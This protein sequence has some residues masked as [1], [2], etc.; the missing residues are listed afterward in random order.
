MRGTGR[1]RG[2]AWHVGMQ[3]LDQQNLIASFQTRLEMWGHIIAVLMP[4]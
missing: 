3:V 1:L 2:K 4:G